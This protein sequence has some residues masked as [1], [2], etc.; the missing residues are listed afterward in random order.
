[1]LSQYGNFSFFIPKSYQTNIL[2]FFLPFSSD[3]YFQKLKKVPQPHI[4]QL[5]FVKGVGFNHGV[6]L[7]EFCRGARVR[8]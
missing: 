6:V 7:S 2:W 8:N 1:M 4:L 5:T 3:F